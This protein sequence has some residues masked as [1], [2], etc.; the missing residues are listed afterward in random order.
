MKKTLSTMVLF[1]AVAVSSFGQGATPVTIGTPSKAELKRFFYDGSSNLQYICT[2]N[3]K[4]GIALW[5]RSDSTLTNIVVSSNTATVTTA[6]AH[7][8]YT[9][10]RVTISGATVDTDLNGTYTVLS[11]ASSTTFTFTTANVSNATYNEATL[12][13]STDYPLLNSAVWAIQVSQY[14]TTTLD[15]TLWASSNVAYNLKCSD[16][17]TY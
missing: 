5:K 1:A 12:V 17:A 6:S 7:F 9:G 4:Q 8:L 13:A 11:S 3:Q 10:A 15:G 14:T 2:A 16:R